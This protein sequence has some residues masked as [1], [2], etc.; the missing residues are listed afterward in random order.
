MGPGRGSLGPEVM[1]M[2]CGLRLMLMPSKH[3]DQAD[4]GP[5]PRRPDR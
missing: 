3:T 4:R 2:V 5:N 1:V